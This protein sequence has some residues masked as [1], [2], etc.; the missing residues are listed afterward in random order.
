MDRKR[1]KQNLPILEFVKHFSFLRKIKS[2]ADYCRNL[3]QISRAITSFKRCSIIPLLRFKRKQMVLA[4]Y[5]PR[6]FIAISL[7]MNKI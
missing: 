4:I 7:Q 3:W 1:Q 5:N 2:K 6:I